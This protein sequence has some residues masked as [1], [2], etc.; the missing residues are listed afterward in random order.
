VTL[1][2]RALS[3]IDDA[4]VTDL[5][6]QLIRL[7]S[8]NPPGQE[9]AVAHALA[10]QARDWGLEVTTQP[11]FEARP[12][13]L[14]R[15]PG[16]GQ[17]PT[18]LYCGHLDTVPPGEMSWEHEPL[19]GDLVDGRLWG[20]GASD[21][22]G[23]LASML[24][25]MGALCQ[26]DLRLPG[27]VVLAAVVG[28]EVDCIGSR[29]YL[30][31]GGM[32]GVAWL[33]I[34][35]PTN[36]DL[37]IAHRGALWLEA[38]TYG[39]TAHGSMPHLGTNAILHM[40]ELIDRLRGWEHPWQVH[41]MFGPPTLSVNTIVGG[42]N[43]NV[44]PDV[45]RTT[46]D[47]RSLPD[48]DHGEILRSLADLADQLAATV[49]DFRVEFRVLNDRPSVQTPVD[50]PLV[51]AAQRAASLAFGAERPIRG[52]TYYTD[53]SV[54]QPPTGVPT[55]II[56][57]GD[58]RLAHQP[59]EFVNVEALVSAAHFFTALPFEVYETAP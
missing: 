4:T 57:P 15:L 51:P 36:L 12:N 43:T 23:G 54:L 19:S 48:Q 13:V 20:R 17:A 1:L 55:L 30:A 39:K 35:E 44:V 8:I 2:D 31:E 29:H 26:A 5:T 14:V 45:C 34:G 52:A 46:I 50:D 9:Q 40:T 37:V 59:N 3:A 25:A 27:D 41:P 32:D 10:S 56:G 33:V 47:I 22:K 49:A 18:L 7:D 38:T 28:E 21:M 42:V 53:A 58:D 24:V 11:V 6:Q 16:T